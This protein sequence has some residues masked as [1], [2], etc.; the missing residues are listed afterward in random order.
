MALA[1]ILLLDGG[2]GTTLKDDF[3]AADD[4][5]LWSSHLLLSDPG[6]LQRAQT[7][8]ARAGADVILSATYQASFEGFART[9]TSS[10][11]SSSS[12]SSTSAHAEAQ[13]LGRE[14]AATLMRSA[15][16]MAVRAGEERGDRESREG[17]G[18]DEG[19]NVAVVALSLGAYGATMVPSQEYSGRY[20]AGH[21]SAGQ[22]R[23][24]HLDRLRVFTT[25]A[26][27]WRA[28]SYVAFETLPL[29]AEIEAVRAAMHLA[30]G[31]VEDKRFWI[32]CVFAGEQR[33]LPDGSAVR[34][35]VR[36]M[37]GTKAGLATPYAIGLN[38]TAV[39]KVTDLLVDFERAVA[40]L[41]DAGEVHAW[42]ALVLY[43][44]GTDGEVYNT[45]TRM[46]ERTDG[47]TRSAEQSWDQQ[48]FNIVR[49]TREK[50]LWSAIL[51]GGCCKTGPRHIRALRARIDTL[52]V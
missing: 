31:E 33:A 18:D 52:S 32:S 2:L 7:A 13:G 22:L 38:C 51:V 23:D 40:S 14:E 34:D 11:S 6:T 9:S 3:D 26:A 25:H 20:D 16:D 24:W 36:A 46:W 45:S 41:V 28:V 10:L 30:C 8:F 44:D 17:K 35:A 5:P 48:L 15:V 27:T 37:L 29:L 47:G 4:H 19:R 1:P 43:P 39:A 50:E 12:S 42:P 21:R 49:R